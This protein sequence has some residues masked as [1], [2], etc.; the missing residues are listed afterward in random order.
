MKNFKPEKMLSFSWTRCDPPEKP[1]TKSEALAELDKI[2]NKLNATQKKNRKTAYEKAKKFISNAPEAGVDGHLTRSYKDVG[3]KNNRIDIVKSEQEKLLQG[4][5]VMSKELQQ[6]LILLEALGMCRGLLVSILQGDF[7][8]REVEEVLEN[9][10]LSN[11][12]NIIGS[13]EEDL[14]MDGQEALD[15][16]QLNRL[17]GIE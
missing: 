17:R 9:T 11:L 4:I 16:K 10:K 6:K 7:S 3:Q 12:A 1:V 15:S 8:M 14:A 2:W 13:T 5:W